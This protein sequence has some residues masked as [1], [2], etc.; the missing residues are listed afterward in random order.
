MN[1]IIEIGSVLILIIFFIGF[2]ILIWVG[3]I[4]SKGNSIFPLNP[5]ASGQIPKTGKQWVKAGL[6]LILLS[7]TLAI[8][9]FSLSL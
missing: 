8:L 9:I 7:I 2:L 4:N 3:I 6:F 1:L 5:T